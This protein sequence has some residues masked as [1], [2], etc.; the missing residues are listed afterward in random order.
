MCFVK[1]AMELGM[2]ALQ[3]TVTFKLEAGSCLRTL[4]KEMAVVTSGFKSIKLFLIG[5]FSSLFSALRLQLAL[6]VE[7]SSCCLLRYV[8][9]AVELAVPIDVVATATFSG[10]PF[11]CVHLFFFVGVGVE[12]CMSSSKTLLHHIRQVS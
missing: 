12:S 1:N 4:T 3:K 5:C 7:G 8:V 2:I 11:F 10:F 9:P 6:V